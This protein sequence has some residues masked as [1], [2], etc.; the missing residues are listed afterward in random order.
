MMQSRILP[1]MVL[2][3]WTGSVSGAPMPA[4]IAPTPRASLVAVSP[5]SRPYLSMDGDPKPGDLAARGYVEEELQIS[6]YTGSTAPY[7]TRLLI[8]RPA[9]VARFSGR[10]IVEV[11]DADKEQEAA[12]LWGYSRENLLRRGDAW[13][14]VSADARA[15]QTLQQF[16]AVRYAP[17]AL[18]NP[19]G[20]GCAD[21]APEVVLQVGA[22]LRSSSK[23]NP[24]W[25]Y[26]VRRI[27]ASGAGRGAAIV[28]A[29]A[30]GLHERFRLGD[31]GPVFDGY[32][33][34]ADALPTGLPTDCGAAPDDVPVV[35]VQRAGR[36]ATVDAQPSDAAAAKL[37]RHYIMDGSAGDDCDPVLIGQRTGYA[38][39]AL[40][41]QLDDWL[42][43]RV[44]LV[45]SGAWPVPLADLSSLRCNES[46]VRV[47]RTASEM[48]VQYRNRSDFRK[49]ITAA[50]ALAVRDRQL[51][52]EDADTLKAAVLAAT[53]GF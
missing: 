1:L 28:G 45:A 47:P 20:S 52:Q 37:Y 17:L 27:L 15:M 18:G 6:G 16:D 38:V 50:A 2:F 36:A 32:Q 48:R 25:K 46:G 42:V 34:I 14:G 43:R 19:A 35:V 11:L 40:W 39:N 51:L 53:P 8:R 5:T 10:A 13:V 22:L 44:P 41:Q 26:S 29:V 31:G 33:Q 7:V 4:Q 21:A 9:E 24:L 23:E 12:P 3:V 30:R 49:R